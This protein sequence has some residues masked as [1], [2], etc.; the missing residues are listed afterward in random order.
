MNVIRN[1]SSES[2]F[3]QFE[4]NKVYDGVDISHI[5]NK[6]NPENTLFVN[7]LGGYTNTNDKTPVENVVFSDN[8]SVIPN[9]DVIMFQMTGMGKTFKENV[10]INIPYSVRLVQSGLFLEQCRKTVLLTC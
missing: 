8:I 2:Q 1:L 3:T 7:A 4:D 6:F 9:M 10:N 5:I